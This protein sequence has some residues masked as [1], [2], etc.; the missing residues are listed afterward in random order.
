MEHWK[1]EWFHESEED[2]S[3]IYSEIGD[4]GY[5]VRKVHLYGDGR[6]LKSDEWHEST[7]IGLSEV[8]VGTIEDVTSQP[9][10]SAIRVPLA[11]FQEIWAAA[12]WPSR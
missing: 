7:E 6:L 4:D 2:P 11:E 12:T 1:V 9:D 10:F 3:L 8:P 5:E